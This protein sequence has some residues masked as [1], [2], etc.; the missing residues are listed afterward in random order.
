MGQ[1]SGEDDEVNSMMN[2]ASETEWTL[3]IKEIT[4]VLFYICMHIVLIIDTSVPTISA[5]VAYTSVPTT[6]A[7][8]ADTCVPTISALIADTSVAVDLVL[9]DSILTRGAQTLVYF[10]STIRSGVR[11]AYKKIS[12]TMNLGDKCCLYYV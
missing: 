5:L 11:P 8:I 1:T 9:T 6:S 3:Y 7:L 12:W 10:F 2:Y 4:R